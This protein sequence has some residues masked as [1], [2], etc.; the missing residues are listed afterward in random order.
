VLRHKIAVLR[1]HNP[2]PTLSGVD[3]AFLSALNKLRPHPLRRLRLVSPRT[4]LRC[5]PT[6]SPAAGLTCDDNQAAHPPHSRSAPWCPREPHLGYR[7]I[8]AELIRLCYQIAASTVWQILK[9]AFPRVGHQGQQL[10]Q[11]PTVRVINL[12]VTTRGRGRGQHCE[13]A[14][15]AGQRSSR[16]SADLG[17]STLLAELRCGPHPRHATAT[18]P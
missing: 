8:Q 17:R 18:R 14:R 12:E 2:R 3:R 15:L 16:G 5:T 7:R 10:Q 1:R 13:H 9:A 4:L 11:T 6:S